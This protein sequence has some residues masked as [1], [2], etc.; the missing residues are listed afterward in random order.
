MVRS[1]VGLEFGDQVEHDRGLVDAHAGGRLV[2][3]VDHRIERD[4]HGNLQLALVA[5]AEPAD[6]L[7]LER[8]SSRTRSRMAI[9]A[10]VSSVWELAMLNRLKP[11]RRRAWITSR[12]F[13]RTVRLG[14]RLVSWKARP[15]PLAAAQGHRV[16]RDVLAHQPDRACGGRDLPEMRLK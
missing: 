3:H 1:L 4:Q 6:L 7:L 14:N 15:S 2:E 10:T 8:M 16:A 13:S 11:I 5:V 9:A 12:T